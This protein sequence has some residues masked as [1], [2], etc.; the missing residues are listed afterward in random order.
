MSSDTRLPP[1]TAHEGS[2]ANNVVYNQ[3]GQRI[4]LQSPISQQL[5]KLVADAGDGLLGFFYRLIG[6]KFLEWFDKWA[7]EFRK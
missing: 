5:S 6:D 7:E 1:F 4:I 3:D 2:D